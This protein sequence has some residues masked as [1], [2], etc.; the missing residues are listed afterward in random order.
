MNS[1]KIVSALFSMLLLVNLFP[2]VF[3]QEE[4]NIVIKWNKVLLQAVRESKLNPPRT[5][6]ALA[7]VHTAIFDAWAAYDSTAVGTEHGGELRRPEEERTQANKEKAISFAAYNTLIDQ[8]PTAKESFD[9]LMEE[10]GYDATDAS[11]DTTTPQGIGNTVA[12][13]ILEFRHTDGSNQLG[14]LAEGSYAD[15][16]GYTPVNSPEEITDPNRW[17]PLTAAD[18]SVQKFLLPQ[19]GMVTPFALMSGNEFRPKAPPQFPSGAYKRETIQIVMISA[20]LDDKSKAIAEYWADGPATETPPGHWN[21]HAQSVSKR[22]G[23]T[24][25]DDAKMFFILGNALLDASIA[26][27]D[28]KVAYDFIRPVSAIRF[29]FNGK[30]IKAFA[31]P[32]QGTQVINGENWSSYISTPAFAEYVSG[33]STFSAASAEVLKLFTGSD[34]FG[35]SVIIAAGS[36]KVEPGNTPS[37]DVTLSWKTFTQAA[38]EAGISRRFGGI[39]FQS[40]DLEARKLGRKIGK[41]VFSKSKSYIDGTASIN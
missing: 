33:H 31:G 22:D 28:A 18:G 10:L 5:A 11:T 32:N 21:L 26:A 25:D 24:L 35:D 19:W 37:K 30:K 23:H 36:S 16:T 29:L 40:G 6:R 41:A 7:I 9:A 34:V 39:H 14:D 4:D 27:W 3:S 12:A 13:S 17:Q 2:P 15:Y 20:A 1:K 38:N 8:I